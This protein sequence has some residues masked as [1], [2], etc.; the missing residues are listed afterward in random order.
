MAGPTGYFQHG[1]QLG[2]STHGKRLS[3]Y[4]LISRPIQS[5]GERRQTQRHSTPTNCAW[6]KRHKC[7]FNFPR[8]RLSTF[9]QQKKCGCKSSR[10]Y[11]VSSFARLMARRISFG[12]WA[13]R[14]AT[15]RQHFCPFQ[16]PTGGCARKYAGNLQS[17]FTFTSGN[18]ARTHCLHKAKP[19]SNVWQRS[20]P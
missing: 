20:T 16:L 7:F 3:L 2:R 19:G 17:G 14:A 8:K 18:P 9:P 10:P 4:M 15:P 13:G 1:R 12:K 6:R 11:S 5:A